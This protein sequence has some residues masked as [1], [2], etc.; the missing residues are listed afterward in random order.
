VVA[1]EQGQLGMI[2]CRGLP[3]I[4][5]V[6]LQAIARGLGMDAGL[7]RDVAGLAAIL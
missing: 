3:T 4:L 7:G 2:E 1:I 6:A 5:L